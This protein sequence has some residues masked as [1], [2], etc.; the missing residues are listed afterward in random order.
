MNF[1]VSYVTFF[2]LPFLFLLHNVK[3]VALAKKSQIPDSD[4]IARIIIIV[5]LWFARVRT[6]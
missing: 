3:V 1:P 5:V 2:P 4:S 6:L